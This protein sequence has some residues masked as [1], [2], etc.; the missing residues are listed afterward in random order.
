M[1]IPKKVKIYFFCGGEELDELL[2]P[3]TYETFA[4][5]KGLGMGVDRL[6]LGIDSHRI[7]HESAWADW[8][9]P[10]LSF[11]FEEGKKKDKAKK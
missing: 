9:Y 3:Q 1:G 4:Q 8:L 11:W 6:R 5:L 10:A 7:H 2:L